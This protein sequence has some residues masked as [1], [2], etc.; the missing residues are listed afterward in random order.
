MEAGFAIP[1]PPH[2]GK[3]SLARLDGVR[4]RT[5]V[6]YLTYTLSFSYL[7]SIFRTVCAM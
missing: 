7:F 5:G 4:I 2:L 1:I 6:L 3:T